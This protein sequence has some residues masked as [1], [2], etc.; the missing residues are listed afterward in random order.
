MRKRW[1]SHESTEGRLQ[2]GR[3]AGFRDALD[4]RALSVEAVVACVV[5]DPRL[6]RQ[7]EDRGLYYARLVA[8]LGIPLAALEEHLFD[9]AAASR[10]LLALDTLECLAAYGNDAARSLLRRYLDEGSAW[11]SA[12]HRLV[13]VS[14]PEEH[15][16]IRRA[17]DGRGSP[18][19]LTD[20]PAVVAATLSSDAGARWHDDVARRA[21][22]PVGELLEQAAQDPSRLVLYARYLQEKS[23]GDSRDAMM[24]AAADGEGGARGAAMIALGELDD[25]RIL[26][27]CEDVLRSDDDRLVRAAY[28]AAT[29]LRTTRARERARGW[30]NR[31]GWLG[32]TGK[33]LLARTGTIDDVPLLEQAFAAAAH[34]DDAYLLC[35]IA[36][37]FA[38]LRDPS[39]VHLLRDAYER[40]VYS[41]LRTECALALEV[42]DPAFGT[43]WAFESL[44]D[45]EARTRLVGCRSLDASRLDEARP[46][47]R[48]LAADPNEDVEVAAAANARA[49]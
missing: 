20:D 10:H 14:P 34:D 40:A 26:D 44:W 24:R 30:A 16:A 49:G 45:C 28:R 38:R 29:S 7:V 13:S 41:Y 2:R 33:T 11:E 32:D 12:L 37:A 3:G 48:F 18:A 17:A 4:D 35:D 23:D 9:D 25:D 31:G 8:E 19:V 36:A 5:D 43:T 27:V 47:L 1:A 46:W 15:D 42:L 21:R 6:D 39:S 22:L